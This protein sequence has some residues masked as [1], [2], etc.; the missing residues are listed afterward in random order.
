MKTVFQ[1]M[2]LSV[3]ASIFASG[4]TIQYS[5]DAKNRLTRV[6]Y[7]DGSIIAYA[8]D[9]EGNRLSHIITDPA[10][11]APKVSADPKALTFTAAAGQAW[12]AT[13]LI[14]LRNDGGGSLQWNALA[15]VPWLRVAP[16]SGTSAGVVNVSASASGLQPGT[17]SGSVVVFASASNTPYNIPVTLTVMTGTSRPEISESGVTT[18]AG[19]LAAVSRGSIATLYGGALADSTGIATTVPLPRTLAGVRVTVNGVDAP[20]WYVSPEQI[21]FQ[22]PF[23]IPLAGVVPVIVK[24]GDVESQPSDVQA[25]EYAP[26]V[27]VYERAQGLFDPVVVHLDGSLV[28]QDNP[29][30]P[31]EILTVYG[32]GLG[33]LTFTPRT[34]EAAPLSPLAESKDLPII[35]L[36]GIPVDVTFSGLVPQSIGLAMFNIRLPPT[37]PE[38]QTLPLIIQFGDAASP[39]VDLA[40]GPRGSVQA[41]PDPK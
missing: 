34:G 16:A 15:S 38:S 39:S 8:Y 10:S 32:T 2:L 1:V 13:R 29:S 36:G 4:E 26:G 37:L 7:A 14:R 24:R 23:E 30:A 35:R 33:S 41:V 17:Y 20:L 40:I 21:N 18:A 19:F 22:V 11:A 5:Y 25:Q 27:F 31:D 9:T 6:T 28:S 12:T 3:V